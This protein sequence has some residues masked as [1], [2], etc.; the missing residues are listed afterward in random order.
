MNPVDPLKHPDSFLH[1]GGLPP[2]FD[3]PSPPETTHASRTYET[4]SSTKHSN[5]TTH[6][7]SQ[8][9]SPPSLASTPMS[10]NSHSFSNSCCNT[11]LSSCLSALNT[12]SHF[13]SSESYNSNTDTSVNRHEANSFR[14]IRIEEEASQRQTPLLSVHTGNSDEIEEP[15]MVTEILPTQD[16]LYR[17]FTAGRFNH[18]DSAEALVKFFKENDLDLGDLIA[19]G[20]FS[21][22]YKIEDTNLVYKFLR[23]GSPLVYQ[24]AI[25]QPNRGDCLSLELDHPNISTPLS[26]HFYKEDEIVE[27]KRGDL[28]NL[29]GSVLTGLIFPFQGLDLLKILEM[30]GP[31]NSFQATKLGFQIASA[32]EYLKRINIV[33]RDVKPDNILCD[34]LGNFRLIDFGLAIRVIGANFPFLGNISE[35]YAPPEF[36][37]QFDP[38]YDFRAEAWGLGI[39]LLKMVTGYAQKELLKMKHREKFEWPKHLSKPLQIVLTGLLEQAPDKRMTIEQAKMELR[40]VQSDV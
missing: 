6:R 32:L 2:L 8:E 12:P 36:K 40:E 31:M 29:R 22:I 28:K 38:T 19:S 23:I 14:E 30:N 18:P 35:L 26:A 1:S 25:Y 37:A 10:Q 16:H 20:A 34:H 33:H 4:L 17:I 21:C 11:P 9:F 27:K 3:L 15:M 13:S 39:V 5:W 24:S 7:L